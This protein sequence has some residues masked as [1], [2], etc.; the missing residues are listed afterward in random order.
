MLRDVNIELSA[1]AARTTERGFAWNAIRSLYVFPFLREVYALKNTYSIEITHMG[2]QTASIAL[3][4]V[5]HLF[6]LNI[7]N[8]QLML[9][10][11]LPSAILAFGLLGLTGRIQAQCPGC[12]INTACATIQPEGGLCPDVIPAATVG[13]TYNQ[14]VS[15]YVPTN[16]TDPSTGIDVTV[17]QITITAINGLPLGLDWECNNALSGCVYTPPTSPPASELGCVKICGTPLGAPGTYTITVDVIAQVIA[18]GITLSQPL[19]FDASIQLLPPVSG[20]TTFTFSGAPNCSSQYVATF[21]A[22]INAA[23]RLTT[24]D[25]NFGNGQTATGQFPAPVAYNPGTYT[26][27]LNTTVFDYKIT[28][29][30]L[31]SMN[32]N[33]CGDIEEPYLFGICTANPDPYFDVRDASSNL[34]YTSSTRDGVLSTSWTGLDIAVPPSFSIE[35][36]DEDVVSQW[37]ALGTFAFNPT[38]PGVYSFSGAGG[39]SGTVTIGT[40]VQTTYSDATDL[41]AFSNPFVGPSATITDAT[42]IG[43][44]NGAIN[45][46]ISGGTSPY[47]YFWSNGATTEDISGLGAGTYNVLIE[48]ANGC[49]T[50]GSFTVNEPINVPCAPAPTGL[51]SLI[52]GPT[53]ALLSWTPIGQPVTGYQVQGRRLGEIGWVSRKVSAP[54]L[55]LEIFEPGR[56]YQFR[57]RAKCS[58][59]GNLSAYSAIQSFTMPTAREGQNRSPVSVSVYPNPIQDRAMVEIGIGSDQEV[60]VSVSDQLGRLV[61]T[62][63]QLRQAGLNTLEVDFRNMTP[64]IYLVNVQT[65]LGVEIRKVVVE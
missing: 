47:S 59:T 20:A 65:E 21:A 30:N 40:S 10:K 64:G 2:N 52:F 39:T 9:R 32:D 26:V 38:G 57:V 61:Y 7:L 22:G 8:H 3:S 53:T 60:S 29:V 56:T 41:I 34:L 46:T 58:V 50:N 15:F 43:G 62:N 13:Q 37:D 51:T 18:F 6:K 55:F 19:S 36:T 1:K 4:C 17:L 54:S 24:W 49:T 5:H 44:N 12:A 45:M 27:S 31:N 14:D 25:W 28:Q 23:P 63:T 35:F 42:T 33:W 48:D 16:A 11:I